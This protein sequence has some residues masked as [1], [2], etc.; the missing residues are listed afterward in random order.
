M[1]LLASP[2]RTVRDSTAETINVTTTPIITT[3]TKE[4]AAAR[5]AKTGGNEAV[6]KIVA[7]IIRV[8]K[9]PLQGM[10]LLVRIAISRSCDESITRAAMTPAA[11]PPNPMLILNACLPCVPAFLKNRSILKAMRGK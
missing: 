4:P 1:K 5:D 10:K 11:L 6:T 7:S 8:G 9:R 3:I 2:L